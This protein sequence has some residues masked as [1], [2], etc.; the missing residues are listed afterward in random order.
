MVAK[1]LNEKDYGSNLLLGTFT[2]NFV[3]WLAAIRFILSWSLNDFLDLPNSSYWIFYKK[4]KKKEG[5]GGVGYMLVD[6]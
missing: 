6:N 1:W 2:K 3:L 5:L 4:K